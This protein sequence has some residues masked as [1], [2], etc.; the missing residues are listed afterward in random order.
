[1]YITVIFILNI[2]NKKTAVF[3][4]TGSIGINSL[5]V[6]KNLRKNEYDI[7][8]EYLTTNTRIDI[9]AEQVKEFSPKGV[10][11]SD[12]VK[13]AE[14]KKNYS[15]PGLEILE[16][17]EMLDE[18]ASREDNNFVILALPG[19][20]GLR[21][22]ISA[23]KKGKRIALANKET[24]VSAGA[25]AYKLCEKY[26]SE[27][28][29]IDSEHSAILQCLAGE[30]KGAIK[31][32]IITASG[33]PFRERNIE[34][35]ISVTVEEALDHPN[36]KMGNKITIDSATL[37][38]KGLEVIEA[39]WLFDIPS[40]RIEVLVHPQS[41]IHSMV[42][43]RDNS[44]KAQLGIPDMKIP[45][46]YAITYPERI[47]SDFPELDFRT[48]S[49]LTFSEPDLEK[50]DCLK[51]AFESLKAGGTYPAVMNIINDK[52]VNMFLDKKIGFMEIPAIIRKKLDS[53]T[54]ITN[55]EFEDLLEIE[56]EIYSEDEF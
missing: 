48:Y 26:G 8:I 25:L 14:F 43:F 17:M 22:A 1:M 50:F 7:S 3:G 11:I 28:L 47:T 33:G 42:E 41:I 15:F 10:V 12:K 21:P 54:S 52:A 46:Q 51:I 36:W 34:T 53:H 6:I 49:Q 27:I 35:L 4:S 45:I 44:I 2:P 29:P 56:R 19:I 31:K 13:A 30:D 20:S 9:L 32:L 16:G 37:M 40:E 5:E 39:R 55:Y 24:L 18:V 38:N 23:L